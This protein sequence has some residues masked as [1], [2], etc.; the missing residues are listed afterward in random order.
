MEEKP[1]S[2]HAVFT[3]GR[4][5]P[6]TTGHKKLVDKV[7][8]H[9]WKT[10]AD[11]YVFASHS[12]DAKKNPLAHHQK[13]KFMKKFF[14]HAN[15]H[16][17]EG[18][19]T[20]L[21]AM[22]HL[23]KKGYKKVTMMVGDDRQQ[24]FHN[25]LQK[26][27]PEGLHVEVKSAGQ[28]D[29][30]AEGVEGMSASK[31]RDH[32]TKKNF[33]EFAK[34]VPNVTH[35]KELYHAVRKGMKLEN[36]QQHFKALFLVGGPGSGKDLIINSLLD[37][38]N[39]IELP[40]EKLNKAISVGE[41]LTELDKYPSLVINGNADNFDKVILSKQVLETMGYDTSMVYVYTS[42]EESKSRNDARLARMAKT[43]T[44]E[45]RHE[46]YIN[47]I[48]NL[49][50]FIPIFECF[51]IFDNSNDYASVEYGKKQEILGWLRE[52]GE[53]VSSFFEKTSKK[54]EAQIWLMENHKKNQA[55]LK[56]MGGAP[57]GIGGK[58]GDVKDGVMPNQYKIRIKK[59]LKPTVKEG[60]DPSANPTGNPFM[61]TNSKKKGKK[62]TKNPKKKS[63]GDPPSF[64]DARMGMVPSGGVGITVSHFVPDG[65]RVI[66]EKSFEKLRKNLSSITNNPDKE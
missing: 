47:S 63:A 3:F 15:I 28:R 7:V 40:L 53:A 57:S 42:D 1:Q 13:I 56:E 27:K 43:F 62:T 21:D 24:E 44:E 14:P 36:F 58:D 46:K 10:H 6:P 22:N 50:N 66:Q 20:A 45:V 32:A 5:N 19:K 39:I 52:L 30:D 54:E 9:A 2:D 59:Q 51:H 64:F 11:N 55:V 65:D 48:K 61:F 31:M 4:F 29:P 23:H 8:S 17:G 34:G 35:A 16:E 12:H 41:N 49:H 18:I 37:K 38:T 60:N 25:L 26:Y 33:A